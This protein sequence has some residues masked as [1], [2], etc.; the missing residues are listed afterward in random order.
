MDDSQVIVLEFV[1]AV[2]HINVLQKLSPCTLSALDG[3]IKERHER[4]KRAKH[5]SMDVVKR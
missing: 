4:M 2:T 1:K 5:K 3:M